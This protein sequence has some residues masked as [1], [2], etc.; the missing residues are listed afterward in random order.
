MR[1][2]P[3]VCLGHKTN[4]LPHSRWSPSYPL[5]LT[6]YSAPI[7]SIVRRHGLIAHLYADDTLLYILFDQDDAA[8]TIK[9]IEAC[10]M[11]IK[12]WTAMNWLKLNDE[13]SFSLLLRTP[14]EPYNVTRRIM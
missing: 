8:E 2:L 5:L 11:E 14:V 1:F 13:K 12:A 4:P 6:L 3:E 7:E 9:R 10:V